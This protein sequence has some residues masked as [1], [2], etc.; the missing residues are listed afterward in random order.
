MVTKA[1][2]LLVV[3]FG[4]VDQEVDRLRGHPGTHLKR[5]GF[6]LKRSL[7]DSLPKSL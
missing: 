6:D 3:G 4:E 2:W 1:L 7:C 5:L